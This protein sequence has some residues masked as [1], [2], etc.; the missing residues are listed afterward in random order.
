MVAARFLNDVNGRSAYGSSVESDYLRPWIVPETGCTTLIF[1]S[2]AVNIPAMGM[3]IDI[4]SI[5][6]TI[7]IRL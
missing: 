7:F 3:I 6:D 2:E 5:K 1:K 4:K